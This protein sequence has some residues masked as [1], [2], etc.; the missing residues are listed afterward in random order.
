MIG[1]GT[2]PKLAEWGGDNKGDAHVDH[3]TPQTGRQS[4]RVPSEKIHDECPAQTGKCRPGIVGDLGA[5][6]GGDE[7][8]ERVHVRFDGQ[9]GEGEHNASEDINDNLDW[10][11]VCDIK[12]P[13][14]RLAS[15]WGYRHTCWLMLP[16]CRPKTA[17]PPNKPAKKLS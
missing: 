17:Y 11:L 2:G 6:F 12:Q 3:A 4:L 10:W 15:V 5:G 8:G 1:E 16:R 9:F 7:G 13:E 14:V